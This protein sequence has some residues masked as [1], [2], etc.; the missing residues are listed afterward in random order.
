[1]SA[2]PPMRTPESPIRSRLKANSITAAISAAVFTSSAYAVSFDWQGLTGSFDSTLSVG[3]IYRLENPDPEFY[4]L[5]NGGRQNSVNADDGNLN[6]R[7]GWASQVFKGTHDLELKYRNFGA[8]VRGTY[9]YDVENKDGDRA[10]TPL[11]DDAL[12]RVGADAQWLDMYLRG[13]FTVAGRSLDLRFG[14]QVLSLGESTFIPN[15]INVINPVEVSKLRVPGSELREALLPVNM[16][17]AALN[18]TDTLSFEAFW[19][20]E[21]RRTEIDP[22]GSYFSSNDFAT[23]GGTNVYLGFG[24]LSDLQPLGAIPRDLDHEGNNYT[25]FGADLK[26]SVPALA[27]TEFGLF[28]AN[29][30][31]RL[32]VISA[33]TPTGPINPNLTGP[34]TAVFIRAGLDP[35]TAAAQASGLYQLIVLAQTNPSALTSGQIAILNSAQSQAAIAG[36]KQIALL[37]A[38]ATGRYFIEYPENIRMLGLSFNTS[39]DSLGIAWQGEVAYKHGVPLQVDDVELLFATLSALDSTGGTNFGA[40]N[41]LGNYRG[42]YSVYVPGFKREDVWSAQTTMT[43]VFGP[44]LRASQLT[45]LGEVGGVYVPGLPA[46]SALRFDGSGTFTGGSQAA[47]SS[48]GFGSVPATPLEA[49]ADDLSWGYQLVAKLDYNNLFRGVNLSPSVSFVHDVQGNTPLPLGNFVEGRK[50]INVTAEFTWQNAW[51]LEFRYVNFFGAGSYN[52][53]SDRDYASTTVKYS[54]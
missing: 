26:L 11:S 10:R 41:Q 37:T 42:Q 30:H 22:A 12:D 1:M 17:K 6:Y 20:L 23:R 5:A 51:S 8:F 2:K 53:L 45:L 46:K 34:L 21:F 43:K 32:P 13:E 54:F 35:A 44:R 29:Y 3:G 40:S 16:V 36:A 50:S 38:A 52:L 25:Q 18:L 47:M 19:L 27:D 14:R 4:G 33:V 31:S 49:F 7:E 48:A 15:G 24:A 9:F 28:F 39:V